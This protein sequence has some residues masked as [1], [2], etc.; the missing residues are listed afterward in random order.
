[1]KARTSIEFDGQGSSPIIE[2]VSHRP[3]PGQIDK[4]V[5]VGR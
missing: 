5:T 3:V 2:L 4:K 1:V